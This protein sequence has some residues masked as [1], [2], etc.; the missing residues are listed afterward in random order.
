MEDLLHALVRMYKHDENG[1]YGYHFQRPQ[2]GYNGI[3]HQ[4]TNA[5]GQQFAVKIARQDARQRAWREYTVTKALHDA[6]I[7]TICPKP[8]CLFRDIEAVNGDVLVSEWLAGTTLSVAPSADEQDKWQKILNGLQLAHSLTP[9]KTTAEILAAIAPVRNPED[10]LAI[11]RK[12]LSRLPEH[13]SGYLE[14]EQVANVV[15]RLHQR[16]PHYWQDEPPLTLIH[17]DFHPANM[18]W[19]DGQVRFVDWENSG[20]ADPAFDVSNMTTFWRYADLPEAHHQW[21]QQTYAK[22]TNDPTLPDR[23]RIYAMIQTVHWVVNYTMFIAQ[24]WDSRPQ[25]VHRFSAEFELKW[26]KHYWEKAQALVT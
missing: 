26:Q 15:D 21:L 17:C 4:A 2:E 6:D 1:K 25:G 13:K 18:I 12:R 19:H 22:M 20:W 5:D 23:V 14:Y 9:D 8:V 7:T 24:K 16:V 10:L 3:V 11:I